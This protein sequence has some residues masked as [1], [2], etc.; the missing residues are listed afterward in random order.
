M[1]ANLSSMQSRLSQTVA[2]RQGSWM[3]SVDDQAQQIDFRITVTQ[4]HIHGLDNLLLFLAPAN[5][6]IVLRRHLK[7]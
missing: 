1:N 5:A 6:V 4:W 7:A 3:D 2:A